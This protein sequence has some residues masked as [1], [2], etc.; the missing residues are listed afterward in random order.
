MT[1]FKALPLLA[2]QVDDILPGD[3]SYG[4]DGRQIAAAQRKDLDITKTEEA[5][6][7]EELGNVVRVPTSGGNGVSPVLA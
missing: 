4:A 1:S 7:S 6:L 5:Q 2:S 3:V